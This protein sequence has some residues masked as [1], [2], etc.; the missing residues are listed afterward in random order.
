MYLAT[1]KDKLTSVG[2]IAAT[3]DD[4]MSVNNIVGEN[5]NRKKKIELLA[6]YAFI[7]SFNREGAYIS[8]N[9][10]GVAFFYRSNFKY[11]GL[12]E[13]F[14]ELRFALSIPFS[15]VLETLKRQTYLNKNRYQGEHFYFWFF[16]VEKGGDK[17][18]FE[19]KDY[20]YQLSKE[21]NLP[22]I[23]ETSVRRNKV[24]YQ[25]YG[26][27]I[28]HTWENYTDDSALWFMIRDPKEL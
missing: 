21:E 3:F 11:F 19:L 17:A 2:I 28:Y 9:K 14:Y 20:L 27:K 12:K 4:N 1:I 23:L 15:K 6:E 22:I 25:R 10:M 5:G 7:K 26:F 8:D 13:M 16:G 18:G 24:V